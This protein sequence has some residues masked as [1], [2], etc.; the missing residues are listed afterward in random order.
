MRPE[1]L[2]ICINNLLNSDQEFSYVTDGRKLNIMPSGDGSN[3]RIAIE[4]GAEYNTQGKEDFIKK[5]TDILIFY[6]G[7]DYSLNGILGRYL[8]D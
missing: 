1:D 6:E 7:D 4:A 3:V 8:D 5:M 2:E